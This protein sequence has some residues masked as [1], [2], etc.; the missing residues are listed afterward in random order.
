M[1]T[2]IVV[3]ALTVHTWIA[4]ESVILTHKHVQ[5][6]GPYL[7]GAFVAFRKPNAITRQQLTRACSMASIWD[8]RLNDQ[9]R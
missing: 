7:L 8:Q 1:Y 9:D 2:G 6:I 5:V 4:N 3:C